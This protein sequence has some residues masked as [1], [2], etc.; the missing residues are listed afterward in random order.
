MK[1]KRHRKN[2]IIEPRGDDW[3][4]LATF[5]PGVALRDDKI[6]VFYRAVGE[7]VNY[8]SRLGLAIFDKELN[9][10]ERKGEP[11]F[12]P[13]LKLWELSIEDARVTQINGFYYFTYVTTITPAPPFGVRKKFGIPKPEQAFSKCAVAVTKD[14]NSFKRLGIVTPH[15]AEERNLVLFPEKFNGKF[16]ALHRPAKWLSENLEKPEVRFAI[17]DIPGVIRESRK[18]LEPEEKWEEKKVGAGPPPIK[19]EKG[20]LLIYHGVDERDVYRAGAALLDLEKPWKVISKLEKPI[21][22][23]E[24]EYER[25]GDVPNVVFPT[26]AVKIEDELLVFYGGADKVCCVASCNINDLIDE[27]I[28]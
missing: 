6:Y 26:G 14:F 12:A 24:K 5:N 1:L 9:L 21:L 23:P 28:P 17:L 16:A 15:D 27:L 13:D 2:P 11:V 25:E 7:Y 20:W 22:E 3:E 10:I 18:V 8:I 4:A 19:T